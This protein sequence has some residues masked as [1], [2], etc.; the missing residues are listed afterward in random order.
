MNA[1]PTA[2]PTP[3]GPDGL[4]PLLLHARRTHGRS[5][6]RLAAQLCA[7][8]G[9]NTVSRHEISRWEREERI[10]SPY[11]LG[12]LSIVLGV[13]EAELD[14]AGARTRSR[15]ASGRLSSGAST[16][17]WRVLAATV[18]LPAGPADGATVRRR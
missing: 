11:W 9:V 14:R 12:W 10:P 15:R 18:R 5:Q 3:P 2:S 8:A 4:G 13:E 17:P 7:V 16:W 6:V 1:S